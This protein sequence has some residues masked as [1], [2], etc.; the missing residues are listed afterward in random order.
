VLLF[1]WVWFLVPFALGFE[2]GWTI[3]GPLLFMVL[4][5]LLT[6]V[7]LIWKKGF[8]LALFAN[9]GLMYAIVTWVI[10]KNEFGALAGLTAGIGWCF[11]LGSCLRVFFPARWRRTWQL[12]ADTLSSLREQERQHLGWGMICLAMPT[13]VLMVMLVPM[14][15][16]P[17]PI[18]LGA[19]SG[20]VGLYGLTAYTIRRSFI[21]LVGWVLL[22]TWFAH[23]QGYKMRFA[24]LLDHYSEKRILNLPDEVNAEWKLQRAFN[25][26]IAAYQLFEQDA[27][28]ILESLKLAADAGDGIQDAVIQHER[29]T[30]AR[31]NEFIK[32]LKEAW[33]QMEQNNHIR[34]P[35]VASAIRDDHQELVKALEMHKTRLLSTE[36]L[37][38]HPSA[39]PASNRSKPDLVV[40]AVSGGGIRA[41]VWTFVVLSHLERAFA[42]RGVDFPAH[43]RLITGASGGMV[44]A[45]Y[46][47]ASLPEPEN[48]PPSRDDEADKKNRYDQ[49]KAQQRAL[50]SDFLTP[51]VKR[52]VLSDLPSWLS[53][54]PLSYDRGLALEQAWSRSLGGALDVSFK[55][56]RDSEQKGWRPSLIFTPMLIEDGRRLLISN[57]DLRYPI[58]NDG[59][60]LASKSDLLYRNNH[61]IEAL[62]LFRLFQ[63]AE[64]RFTLATAA[65]MSASFPFFSPAVSLPTRPRRRVVDAGYYDNYG[66]SLATSWLFSRSNQPWIREKFDRIVLIQI[67]DGQSEDERQLQK[68]QRTTST[69]LGRSTEEI[70]APPEGL[71]TAQFASSSFRNDGLLELYDHF[72]ALMRLKENL[73]GFARDKKQMKQYLE[74]QKQV[75]SEGR[76]P[77]LPRS[78]EE[79]KIRHIM[80]TEFMVMNFELDEPAS[81]SW[82]LTDREKTAITRT[83]AGKLKEKIT[84]LLEWWAPNGT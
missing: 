52:A 65:R 69:A 73:K 68:L 11:I 20:V 41:A 82:Y 78:L 32:N 84:R 16:S 74:E 28:G 27:E 36:N 2:R 55:D 33:L 3:V 50:G 56:L 25:D 12:L 23:I 24:P 30:T 38:R 26:T 53:P 37:D 43:V 19:L 8:W 54:W 81:T 4:G 62:E 66:V 34:A 29:E 13:L 49:L 40:I 83:A 15:A 7:A 31:R 45:S 39:R 51:L 18:I 5:F 77:T 58:S 35:H 48:R 59:W 22:F 6:V 61:S 64:D 63:G 10:S 60:V 46:Y 42:E 80:E 9:L 14:F 47:I 21:V 72:D 71:Y 70:T 76:E 79:K 17:A 57:L 44:G 1:A 75:L 67:R